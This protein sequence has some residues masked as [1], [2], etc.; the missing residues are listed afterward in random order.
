MPPHPALNT[1]AIALIAAAGAAAAGV[2]AYA[3]Q[4]KAARA[5]ARYA[6][7]ISGEFTATAARTP[8]YLE[9][10]ID[11]RA[12][13]MRTAVSHDDDAPY[14]HTL[15]AMPLE[16][17]GVMIAGLRRKS[18]LEE[19]QTRSRPT[20][21]EMEAITAGAV[22]RAQI[23]DPAFVRSFFLVCNDAEHIAQILTTSVREELS[24]WPDV[25]V[26]IRRKQIEWRRPGALSDTASMRRLNLM[27]AGMA[28]AVDALPARRVGL[29]R[30]M[31]DEALIARGV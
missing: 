5:W 15:A 8:D 19:A 14:F 25:E 22:P 21:A 24:R 31:E 2:W 28:A 9:G 18:M 17:P 16:N 12:L 10:T 4:G 20:Y 26:Y 29:T 27:L 1:G 7:E 11:G 23:D 13:F 3:S 30:L 6:H